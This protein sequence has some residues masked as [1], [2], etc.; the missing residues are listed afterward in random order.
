[1]AKSKAISTMVFTL[2][3][4]FGA[5]DQTSELKLLFEFCVYP[6][7]HRFNRSSLLRYS[8]IGFI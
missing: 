6:P 7:R 5:I 4:D 3:F 1:M 2:G 8:Y